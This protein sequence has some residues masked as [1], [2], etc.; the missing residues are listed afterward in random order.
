MTIRRGA[1]PV[2]MSGLAGLRSEGYFTEASLLLA[3]S[4][5]SA[6]LHPLS[7]PAEQSLAFAVVLE[8]H[9]SPVRHRYNRC[10]GENAC[11]RKGP[12]IGFGDE[13]AHHSRLQGL[14][15]DGLC[16]LPL[17]LVIVDFSHRGYAHIM[18]RLSLRII[19]EQAGFR[20]RSDR[21]FAFIGTGRARP[22]R[23][24]LAVHGPR[25]RFRGHALDSRGH[26]AGPFAYDR[27]RSLFDLRWRRLLARF[28]NAARRSE[29]QG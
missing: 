28:G 1:S 8:G 7:A 9:G 10:L 21:G 14:E 2:R 19:G 6:T 4:S 27:V 23:R 29:I 3:P 18:D 25:E 20:H 12:A 15:L 13:L 16:V 24:R 5:Q 17:P 22:E 11:F 26:L